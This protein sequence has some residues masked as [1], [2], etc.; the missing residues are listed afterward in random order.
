LGQHQTLEPS[1]SPDPWERH[2]SL[3]MSLIGKTK[4]SIGIYLKN[5]DR[6]V[7]RSIWSLN[8]GVIIM[9]KCGTTLGHGPGAIQQLRHGMEWSSKI[10]VCLESHLV[11]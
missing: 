5:E 3:D 1:W 8:H 7:A 11:P 10:L 4:E 9:Q 2:I 6:V